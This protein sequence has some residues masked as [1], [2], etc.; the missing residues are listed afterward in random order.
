MARNALIRRNNRFYNAIIVDS[1]FPPKIRRLLSGVSGVLSVIC[2]LTYIISQFVVFLPNFSMDIISGLFMVFISIWLFMRSI[3][4]F[5]RSYFFIDEAR[6]ETGKNI[7]TIQSAPNFPVSRIYYDTKNG[8]LIKAFSNSLYGDMVLARLGVGDNEMGNFLAQRKK[9]LDFSRYGMELEK[10]VDLPSLTKFIFNEDKDF[11]DF[12]LQFEIK[13]E[14]LYGAG[15]WVERDFKKEIRVKR[16]WGRENLGRINGIGGDW[17]Y[18]GAYTLGKYGKAIPYESLKS[19]SLDNYAYG[20]EEVKKLEMI[21]SREKEANALLVGEEGVGKDDVVKRFAA[22]VAKGSVIANLK[23]RKVVSLDTKALLASTKIKSSF[24]SEVIKIFNDIIKSGNIILVIDNFPDFMAGAKA[25]GSDLASLLDNYLSSPAIQVIALA[26]SD[27]FHNTIASNGILMR[28]FEVVLMEEANDSEVILVLEDLAEKLEAK[29]KIFFTYQAI[30]TIDKSAE[31]YLTDG[32][33]P[34]KALD[35]M[36][37]MVPE[38][39]SEERPGVLRSDV[40]D[41]VQ[42]KT[43]MPVGVITDGE[44]EKL[45]HLEELLHER[46]VGQDEA[47]EVISDALRRARAGV[48]NMN[49]P[50]GTFL[51]IGPTGVGK[52]EVAKTL[53]ESFFGSEGAMSRLDMSEYQSDEGLDKLIGSFENGRVGA[54][55]KILKER[56]YG[57]LLLDEFEKTSSLVLDLFLQILDEGIFHD[58][59]GKKVNAR[60]IIFIATSNAASDLIRQAV[61]ERGNLASMKD[62][63]IEKI[64]NSGVF[65]PEL[66][67]RFDGIVLFH[68]L[69]RE[70]YGQIAILLLKQ[71]RERMRRE[72]S[73]DLIVNKPLI[74]VVISK[75]SD[76]Q[77]GARPMKRA[78]QTEIEQRI[79]DKII[80]GEIRSGSRV[81]FSESDFT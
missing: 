64:I 23:G 70:H 78:I 35:L 6:L 41:F 49:R 9:I 37:E 3:E 79:A 4:W 43:N 76:Q 16:W 53:A 12:L 40:L 25:L 24:E 22:R 51:F 45:I 20:E 62:V 77:F 29:N 48:R 81:E 47:I 56:P 38:F 2:I 13:A 28:R 65:K 18:G 46:I 54:L 66:L 68:P 33:M 67:N 58:M 36:I 69:S 17:A 14:D 27:R 8:D 15:S 39:S 21:L 26:D 30:V 50:M 1:V 10:V 44:R 55:T 73:I 72:K 57:V 80:R 19:G 7:L 63:I 5:Y 52:T 34:D 59:G 75:G 74:D 11:R 42:Q 32:V 31:N 71:L 61:K 60:N